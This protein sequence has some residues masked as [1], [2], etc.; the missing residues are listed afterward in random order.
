MARPFKNSLPQRLTALR[1]RIDRV[2]LGLLRLLNR[3]ATLAV[4]VGEL[5]RRRSQAVWDPARER[6]VLEHIRRANHGPLADRAVREIFSAI[7]RAS[8]QLQQS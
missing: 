3:R 6:R 4:R 5:K 1:Q 7:L 2:D 8:R